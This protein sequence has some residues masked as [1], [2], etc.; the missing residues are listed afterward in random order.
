MVIQN[1]SWG[2]SDVGD[3]QFEIN[4]TTFVTVGRGLTFAFTNVSLRPNNLSFKT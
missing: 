1:L 3:S 2:T 4:L